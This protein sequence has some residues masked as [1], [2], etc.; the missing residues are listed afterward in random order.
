MSFG[1]RLAMGGGAFALLA[2]LLALS[3]WGAPALENSIEADARRTLDQ[4]N[5]GVVIAS[6][7]GRTVKIY[8]PDGEPAHERDAM[9]AVSVLA[10]VARVE[11]IDA[12]R[13][14]PVEEASPSSSSPAPPRPEPS[15][16]PAASEPAIDVAAAPP[17]VV[18]AEPAP[19]P[20]DCEA[21]INRTLNGRRLVFREDSAQLTSGDIALLDEL[22]AALGPCAGLSIF[23]EGHTDWT[24]PQA[25]NVRL[26][27]QRARIV[28]AHLRDRVTSVTLETRGYG[29]SRPIASN[30]SATGRETNRRIDFTVAG[31][32]PQS[33]TES[34]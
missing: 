4:Q 11:K 17:P 9:A 19:E 33:A 23:V 20:A 30:R 31:P 13:P 5:L 10:G 8:S 28:E 15:P 2:A 12:V 27:E 7:D 34:Q 32:A 24:G 29:E 22:A 18:K 25:A 14:S 21:A 26:S 6:A 3:P 16:A 1:Q